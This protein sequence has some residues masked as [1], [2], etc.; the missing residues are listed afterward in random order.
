MV[1]ERPRRRRTNRSAKPSEVASITLED[2]LSAIHDKRFIPVIGDAIRLSHIF[3]IDRD[4]KIGVG[5]SNDRVDKAGPQK[6]NVLET[7]ARWWAEDIKYPLTDSHKLARVAQYETARRD[8][9]ETV[10]KKNYIAF[11]KDVL[12]DLMEQTAKQE[13]NEQL[14]EAIEE[15]DDDRSKS[16]ADVVDDLDCPRFPKD[17]MDPLW[18]LARMPIKIYLTTSHF[19]F[20]E[21][22]LLE[23]GTKEPV[24]R[25]SFWN[26]QPSSVEPE[27]RPNPTFVPTVERPVVYHLFGIEQY[28]ESMVLTEDDYLRFYWKLATDPPGDDGNRTIPIYLQSELNVSSQLLLGYRLEDWDLRVL[29]HGVLDPPRESKVRRPPSLAIQID[30]KEQSLVDKQKVDK[31]EEYLSKYF[32]NAN[33]TLKCQDSDDFVAE[34]WGAWQAYM[35]GE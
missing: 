25:F 26:M 32:Q 27:H 35:N 10:A 29:L 2:I 34:L 12:L 33:F 28:P 15:L 19:D 16:F 14:M 6:H 9:Y 21:R 5:S 24:T 11:M 13:G 17:T 4:Q 30:P 31:A 18:V 23:T 3:D 7:L 8:F 1:V 22:A 20:M